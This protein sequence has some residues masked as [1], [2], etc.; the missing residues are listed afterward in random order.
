VSD[1]RQLIPPDPAGTQPKVDTSSLLPARIGRPDERVADEHVLEAIEH[2]APALAEPAGEAPHAAKFQ[3]ILGALIAVA[4]V[5][6]ASLFVVAGSSEESSD[7]TGWSSW[8]PGDNGVEGAQEI[9]DHVGPQYR[10]ASNDQLVLVTASKL[11]IA[12]YDLQMVVREPAEQGGK[13]LRV[14]GDTMLYKFCG[15]GPHCGIHGKP[16]VSRGLLLR[17]EAL[18]LALYTLRYIKGVDQV[19]FFLP[20]S[21]A[22]VKTTNGKKENIRLDNQMLLYDRDSVKKELAT[23][24]RATLKAPP[25][26]AAT[27]RK[28]PD[29]PFVEALAARGEFSYSFSQGSADQSVFLVLERL[30][31]KQIIERQKEEQELTGP[32]A[33]VD[34]ANAAATSGADTAPGK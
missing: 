6:I 15:L 1:E 12:D 19:A 32:A 2:D 17:R 16:T 23:P 4:I 10:L 21:Y 28:S 3:F 7:L 29:R 31:L 9:A 22:P 24:L 34:A 14:G 13:I 5:G 33:Q 11:E 25:P 18:E 20:P 27:V 26:S 8:K 30:T